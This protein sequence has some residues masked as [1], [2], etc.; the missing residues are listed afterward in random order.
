MGV[1]GWKEGCLDETIR[2][3]DR[4]SP[5]GK[6]GK[7]AEGNRGEEESGVSV[8][9]FLALLAGVVRD[10]V[11]QGTHAKRMPCCRLSWPWADVLGRGAAPVLCASCRAAEQKPCRPR[12]AQ[13]DC[14]RGRGMSPDCLCMT[15][16]AP[17]HPALVPSNQPTRAGWL[18]W[19]AAWKA[20][21]CAARAAPHSPNAGETSAMHQILRTLGKSRSG[22]ASTIT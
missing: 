4:K 5:I 14:L 8:C 16:R 12:K 20:S 10:S 6:A 17:L 2:D 9:C 15:C 13:S 21:R 7:S 3:Q 1:D 19:N 22:E 11:G 18:Q